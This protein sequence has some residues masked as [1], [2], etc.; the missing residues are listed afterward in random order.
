MKITTFITII[1]CF[2]ASAQAAT[3]LFEDFEPGNGVATGSLDGQN[4]WSVDSGSGDVQTSEVEDGV[5]AL[6]LFNGSVSKEISADGSALW[7][8][9][10]ARIAEAP[11][12]EP[13]FDPAGILAVFY[14][15]TNLN[16]VVL[17]NGVPVELAAQMPTN[18]WTRFD[19]YC[20]SSAGIWNLAMNGS[21]VADGLPLVSSNP[22]E[23]VMFSNQSVASAFLDSLDMADAEQVGEV[24]DTD[25]D[26]LPDWWEQKYFG[27]ATDSRMGEDS[28]GNGDFS[29]EET[30]IAALDPFAYDPLLTAFENGEVLWIPKTSRL[31]DVEW[32]PSLHSNFVA[33]A[34]DI[35]WPTDSYSDA[36]HTNEPTGFY[37]VKIHL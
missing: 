5:Q 35:P 22:A 24:P 13:E 12:A 26:D 10:Q 15:N 14:V 1:G 32:A 18:I 7:M 6:E 17:S 9:F 16:L 2:A 36:V 20:D 30:Y 25:G 11:Q 3:V 33:V 29:Y 8:H 31:H 37:R 23:Q 27:D 28:S 19:V 34:S 4:G 21:N